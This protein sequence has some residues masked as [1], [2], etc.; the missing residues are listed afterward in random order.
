MPTPVPKDDIEILGCAEPESGFAHDQ[1]ARR[2]SD[3]Q[4][5]VGERPEV[6][7]KQVKP[8]YHGTSFII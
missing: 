6:R 7:T 2:P 8:F 5:S 4:V 1:I 3:E